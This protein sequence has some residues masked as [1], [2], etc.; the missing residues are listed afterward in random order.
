V[1]IANVQP[2]FDDL[3]A[4][5]EAQRLTG[6]KAGGDVD[7]QVQLAIIEARNEFFMRLGTQRV[8]ALNS[9][10]EPADEPDTDDEHLFLLGYATEQ[11]LIRS[12]LLRYLTRMVKEGRAPIQEWNDVAAFRSMSQRDMRNELDR[13]D[14]EIERAFDVIAGV[15]LPGERRSVSA[16]SIGSTLEPQYRKVGFSIHAVPPYLFYFRL[17]G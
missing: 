10:A 11:K 3:D 13:L 16:S 17:D 15:V 4:T 8:G 9:L 12:S 5:K 7:A 14:A 6:I 1:S 2:I